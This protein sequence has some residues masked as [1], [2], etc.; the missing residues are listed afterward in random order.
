M[1]YG[2]FE[3]LSF[4]KQAYDVFDANIKHEPLD[5]NE[6]PYKEFVGNGYI[7]ITLDYDSPIYIKSQRALSTPIYW[8]P[9][10]KIGIEAPSQLA[11]VVNYKTG[12]AYRYECF[13]NR[14]QTSIKYFA[15]R[16]LPSILIQDIEISNPTDLILIA[17]LNQLPY[18]T[19]TWSM[20]NTRIIKY[21]HRYS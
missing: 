5:I 14:L 16:A 17:K 12:I 3:K 7:G 4:H 1:K 15:F 20:Y 21:V 18:K 9:L 11:T 8:H 10:I 19:H 13:A 6:K 2:L